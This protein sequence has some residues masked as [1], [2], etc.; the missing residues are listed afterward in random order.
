MNAV[1]YR[2]ARPRATSDRSRATS[3]PVLPMPITRTDWPAN[4]LA[5]AYAALWMSLPLNFSIPGMDGIAGSA[6]NPDAMTTW[7]ALIEDAVPCM[8]QPFPSRHTERAASPKRGFK[9]N[10]AA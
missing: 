4:G 6:L 1:A 9:S 2:D 3:A 8:R 7:G 10:F 5:L